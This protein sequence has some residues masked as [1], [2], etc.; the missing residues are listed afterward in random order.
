MQKIIALMFVLMFALAACG[1]GGGGS[2]GTTPGTTTPNITPPDTTPPT[3]SAIVP[4]YGAT[5]ALLNAPVT[6]TFSE[7]MRAS[8]I[9]GA[10]FTLSN[11]ATGTVTYSGTTATFTP[12]INL[13]LSTT[14]TAFITTGVKDLAGNPMAHYFAWTFT[15]CIPAFVD[16]I[17]YSTALAYTMA[18]AAANAACV[19]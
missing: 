16:P 6:V 18:V 17:L 5:G 4:V 10:T 13:A 9:T 2:G 14:Y 12:T 19:G 3:V 11:G 15:T 1:G 8:T 7:P